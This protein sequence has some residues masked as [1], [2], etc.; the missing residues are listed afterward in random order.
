MLVVVD[1]VLVGFVRVMGV[2]VMVFCGLY[3][4]YDVLVDEVIDYL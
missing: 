1:Y 3:C 4:V 2:E